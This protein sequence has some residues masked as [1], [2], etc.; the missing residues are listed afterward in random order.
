MFWMVIKFEIPW[1]YED[2]EYIDNPQMMLERHV[3]LGLCCILLFRLLILLVEFYKPRETF[4]MAA[5]TGLSP[6]SLLE[7]SPVLYF[8][9]HQPCIRVAVW[10]V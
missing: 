3:G 5:V 7:F 4:F 1:W 2:L 9:S 6:S 8:S 10:L